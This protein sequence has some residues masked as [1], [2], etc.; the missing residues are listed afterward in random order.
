F[1][2]VARSIA[3]TLTRM[4][5][6]RPDAPAAV[7]ASDGSYKQWRRE[8]T[9]HLAATLTEDQLTQRRREGEAMDLDDAVA[10]ALTEID[11]ALTDPALDPDHDLARKQRSDGAIRS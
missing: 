8:A 1:Q 10:Y 6:P 4:P 2:G 5:G 7:P 3:R 11:N 9:H